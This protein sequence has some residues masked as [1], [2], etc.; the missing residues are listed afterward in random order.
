MVCSQPVEEG[1]YRKNVLRRRF[2]EIT[3]VFEVRSRA[4]QLFDGLVADF[5][6]TTCRL[7][8]S[9]AFTALIVAKAVRGTMS[10]CTGILRKYKWTLRASKASISVKNR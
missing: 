9:T 4:L 2:V 1:F 6:E 3:Y 10:R 8:R 7:A 5:D